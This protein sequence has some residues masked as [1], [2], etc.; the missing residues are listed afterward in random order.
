MSS[1]TASA[2]PSRTA[3]PSDQPGKGQGQRNTQA[4]SVVSSLMSKGDGRKADF[5]PAMEASSPATFTPSIFDGGI[6][7]IPLHGASSPVEDLSLC[8]ELM[9]VSIECSGKERG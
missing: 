7:P 2:S 6:E 4:R 9:L 5:S 3:R 8:S 1:T